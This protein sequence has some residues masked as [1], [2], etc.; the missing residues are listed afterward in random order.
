ME[1]HS[2]TWEG[3]AI[4]RLIPERSKLQQI[5]G[6]EFDLYSTNHLFLHKREILDLSPE[7]KGTLV[8]MA[9]DRPQGDGKP[10]KK[11]PSSSHILHV[12]TCDGFVLQVQ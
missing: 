10:E 9:Q 6:K 5:K 2:L 4:R 8:S 1:N 7:E 11:V 12:R 3:N